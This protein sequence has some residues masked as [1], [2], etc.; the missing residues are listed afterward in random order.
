MVKSLHAL[1]YCT[2]HHH[3]S[4]LVHRLGSDL[5]TN[6][7]VTNQIFVRVGGNCCDAKRPASSWTCICIN[8]HKP[9]QTWHSKNPTDEILIFIPKCN[10][11]TIPGK[12]WWHVLLFRRP[13]KSCDTGQWRW[14]VH[15]IWRECE[16]GCLDFYIDVLHQASAVTTYSIFQIFARY[17]WKETSIFILT[18][19]KAYSYS[20][21]LK[22]YVRN[23]CYAFICAD[24]Y[25]AAWYREGTSFY[26]HAV[27]ADA[28]LFCSGILYPVWNS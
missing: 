6:S 25:Y 13:W 23:H 2:H 5:W 22:F 8:L 3:E 1:I 11:A 19:M 20:L 24:L 28:G 14:L 17:A 12:R 21:L 26:L 10:F 15:R 27:Y 7:H 18:S 16:L 4:R 9:A